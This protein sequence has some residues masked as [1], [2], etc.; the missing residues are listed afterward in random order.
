MLLMPVILERINKKKL[1][2]KLNKKMEEYKMTD[3]VVKQVIKVLETLEGKTI[4]KRFE[5][6]V[7]EGFNLPGYR[8][9][10]C[11]RYGNLELNIYQEGEHSKHIDFVLKRSSTNDKIFNMERF[12]KNNPHLRY[13]E[14]AK[15]LES[16]IKMINDNEM[17]ERI[18]QS[19]DTINEIYDALSTNSKYDLFKR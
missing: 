15:D 3:K 1:I 14:M 6:K 2:E 7:K 11:E 8:V 9:Y 19:V 13:D 17:V 18:N 10:Y 4:T 12:Y 16:D 5:T